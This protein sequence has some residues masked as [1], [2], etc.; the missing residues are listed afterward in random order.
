MPCVSACRY[1]NK[2]GG[3]TARTGKMLE[4]DGY[5]KLRGSG[6]AK[7]P[8]KGKGRRTHP[9]MEFSEGGETLAEEEVSVCMCVY[10]SVLFR[11]TQRISTPA[12]A[13]QGLSACQLC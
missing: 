1:F 8:K 7:G 12:Y 2:E 10:L 4:E 13:Y 6:A 9:N 3:V 5:K 11:H